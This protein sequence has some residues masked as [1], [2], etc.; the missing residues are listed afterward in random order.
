V[1]VKGK[2][3]AEELVA[4]GLVRVYG[5]RANWPDGLRST[6]FI[7]QLKNLELTAREQRRG[8]WDESAFPRGPQPIQPEV[9]RTNTTVLSA[10]QLPAPTDLN[11]ATFEELQKLPGIGRTLAQRIIAHRPYKSV[12]D[13]DKVPGF[14]KKLIDHL[15]PFVRIGEAK[16]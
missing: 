13:L 14:G 3:L 5:L 12:D 4:N 8:I 16:R 11:K 10:G 6:T 7:N 15:R 2:N 1:L 9:P